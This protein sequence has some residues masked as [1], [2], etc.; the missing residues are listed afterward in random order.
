[1]SIPFKE[2]KNV[3]SHQILTC[4]GHLTAQNGGTNGGTNGKT[5]L[6]LIKLPNDPLYPREEEKQRTH[7]G[8]EVAYNSMLLLLSTVFARKVKGFT[9]SLAIL[10]IW[11]ALQTLHDSKHCTS[12]LPSEQLNVS[13]A[14][15]TIKCIG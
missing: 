4:R 9:M 6:Q 3:V 2:V 12:Q 10:H 14:F 15:Q 7:P 11:D 1:M 13:N 5:E 8:D